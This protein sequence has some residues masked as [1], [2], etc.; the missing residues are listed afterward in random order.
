MLPVGQCSQAAAKPG[1]NR[2]GEPSR[3]SVPESRPGE[4]SSCGRP[5]PVRTWAEQGLSTPESRCA[6]SHP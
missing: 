1:G 3:G 6:G 5:A 2:P 4:A